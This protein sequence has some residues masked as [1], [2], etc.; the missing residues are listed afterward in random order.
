MSDIDIARGA[1]GGSRPSLYKIVRKKPR[2]RFGALRRR[3]S[4]I[5][6]RCRPTHFWA[7]PKPRPRAGGRSQR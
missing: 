2:K 7:R 6:M 5:S 1:R 3:S 4:L